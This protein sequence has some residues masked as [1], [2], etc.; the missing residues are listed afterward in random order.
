[1][2]VAVGV[3]GGVDSSVALALLKYVDFDVVGITMKIWNPKY[4]GRS[5]IHACFGP[6]EQEEINIAEDVCKKL[7]VPHFVIDCSDE[8]ERNV[9][10]YFRKEY[11]EGRTPNPCVVCN[12]T[13]KFGNLLDI[14]RNKIEFDVFATGHYVIGPWKSIDERFCISRAYH[15]AKDQSYFLCR[16]SQEQLSK[17]LFPL[18]NYLKSEIRKKAEFFGLPTANIK[19]SQNFYAGNH[20]E[21]ITSEKKQGHIIDESGSEIGTH[22]G[23][24]N[25]TIGQKI[26]GKYVIDIKKCSNEIVVGEINKAISSI[27]K[28]SDIVYVSSSRIEEGKKYIVKV[29]SSG[30]NHECVISDNVVIMKDSTIITPGQF[31]VFYSEIGVLEFSGVISERIK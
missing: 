18:G 7:S 25:Y 4:N 2:K 5:G 3:S 31:A 1:M 17:T 28:I 21:L 8:Y 27:Y 20:R 30:S 26:N 6:D 11:L 15:S 12:S 16:L 23:Y 9:L 22:D 10:A 13:M 29:R 14:A 24:W 19:D